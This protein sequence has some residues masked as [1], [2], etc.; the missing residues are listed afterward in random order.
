MA[1]NN[2]QD[3]IDL[4]WKKEVERRISS[5]KFRKVINWGVMVNTWVTNPCFP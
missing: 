1:M 4:A 2:L 3:K 5:A